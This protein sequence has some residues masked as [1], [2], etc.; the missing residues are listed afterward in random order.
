MNKIYL[1][2]HSI[3]VGNEEGIIQG[4]ID[5]GLSKKGIELLNE[6]DYEKLKNIKKL[7]KNIKKSGKTSHRRNMGQMRR[8]L[9]TSAC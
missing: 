5:Y 4:N 7:S 3:S 6:F 2:R 8:F 9:I 1:V